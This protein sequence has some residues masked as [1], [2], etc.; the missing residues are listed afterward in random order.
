[1]S[2]QALREAFLEMQRLEGLRPVRPARLQYA[3]RVSYPVIPADV[4]DHRKVQIPCR[5]CGKSV[6]TTVGSFRRR[7]SVYYCSAN[8][9]ALSWYHDQCVVLTDLHVIEIRILP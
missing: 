8:C 6:E 7:T 3:G 4:S 2:E 9:K 1:M 5:K